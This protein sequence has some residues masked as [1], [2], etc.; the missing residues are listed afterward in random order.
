[1]LKDKIYD[2]KVVKKPWGFEYVALRNKNK[3][4]ITFLNINYKKN[5]SS[6]PSIKKNWIYS[7]KRYSKNTAR[8]VE[9]NSYIYKSPS[10]LMI[11]TG[12]FHSIEAISKNGINALEFETP[13]KKNDLVRYED[14]YGRKLK[15]Y[16]G[17]NFI[18][19]LK[20]T[21]FF[22]KKAT[23]SVDQKYKLG[24]VKIKLKVYKTF[25]NIVNQK[26]KTIFAVID[27]NIIDD[28]NRKLL[29]VGDIIK[30]GT[31]KK[32]SKYFKINKSITLLSVYS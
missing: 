2:R 19:P 5:I 8:F 32:L 11:R 17:K 21:D 27:G 30:T 12:L 13:V 15:P 1:M 6:L 16:E 22:F 14:S 18:K 7:F 24:K 4:A 10:K 9:K 25:D 20:K 23:T 26:D 3:L 31:F 29:S 28:K